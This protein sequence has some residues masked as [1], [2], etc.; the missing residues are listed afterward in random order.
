VTRRGPAP[1]KFTMAACAI[2]FA[3]Q[4]ICVRGD[5]I[6]SG[7]AD[8]TLTSTTTLAAPSGPPPD[9][10]STTLNSSVT[11]GSI[12]I[13]V[14]STANLAVGYGVSGTGIPSGTT[15][16]QIDAGLSQV[17]LSQSATA[18]GSESLVFSPT[19]AP[20]QVV[21]L[22]Q[23]A[24]GVVTPPSSATQGPLT[25]LS[26]S[27]DIST[28]GVY[29]YLA[30]T[31]SNGQPLQALGLSFYGNGLANG[32]YLK[33]SLNVANQSSP[34]QLISKTPGITITYDP[35]TSSVSSN[36]STN[37]I[38]EPISVVLWGVLGGAGLVR[39]RRSR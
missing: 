24:G 18:S 38:P 20:P 11:S 10:A 2:L 23:P 28:S 15:I 3:V 14:P 12:T 39:L 22:I 7:V 30:S 33:F 17:T 35:P 26:A 4:E 16:A 29:D 31:T 9:T 13:T 5:G 32:D 37:A 34:P 1:M 27:S 6:V 8:Y 36:P 25:I 19:I 21:A